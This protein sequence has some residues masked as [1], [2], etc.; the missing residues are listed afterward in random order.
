MLGKL[1]K[2][3]IKATART[4]LPL[5][6]VLLVFALVNRLIGPLSQD[7][8]RFPNI[9]SMSLY[10][11]ILIG[12]FV[13]TFIVMIS[14]FYKNLLSDEGY[15]M[16]TL[17]TKTWHHITSKLTV[18]VMWITISIITAIA[19]IMIIASREVP[20]SEIFNA[21]KLAWHELYRSIGSSAYLVV[22]EILIASILS[23][24]FSV[25]TI[26]TSI[27]LGHLFTRHKILASFGAYLLLTTIT[28]IIAAIATTI[29][30]KTSIN[31]L[32]YIE[33]TPL[34]SLFHN[35]MWLVII[36]SAI[37]STLYFVITNVILTERLN[38]E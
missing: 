2:Y 8:I 7:S 16:F 28:Q 5:Y 20:P 17:P 30:F 15:L 31:R 22:A 34:D 23:M 4:F 18:S 14:R 1:M 32:Q 38:L 13:M 21:I 9:I 26:Y 27:A 33:V 11:I 25:L 3:E 6:I 29:M 12:M 24:I 35:L 19:S 36:L 37:M 10:V